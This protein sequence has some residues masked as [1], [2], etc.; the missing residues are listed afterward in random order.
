MR[1]GSVVAHFIINVN[2]SMIIASLRPYQ[3]LQRSIEVM[4]LGRY[5]DTYGS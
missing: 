1:Y 4:G 3:M 2:V 5:S